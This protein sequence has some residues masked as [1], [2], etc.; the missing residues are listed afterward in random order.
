MP[1][2]EPN[3]HREEEEVWARPLG[4][5][6]R[7]R[8]GGRVPK[9]SG[10]SRTSPLTPLPGVLVFGLERRRDGTL[11]LQETPRQ[12]DAPDHQSLGEQLRGTSRSVT[13]R[14]PG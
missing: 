2:D 9:S 6:V 11:Q 5:G 8:G 4:Q 12:L 7:A 3:V 10:L 14:K 13:P 1:D